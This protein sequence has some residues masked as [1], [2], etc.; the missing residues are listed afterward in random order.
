VADFVV[1]VFVQLDLAESVD[2]DVHRCGLHTLEYFFRQQ[3]FDYVCVILDRRHL[4]FEFSQRLRL[5]FFSLLSFKLFLPQLFG[6]SQVI[7]V[8]FFF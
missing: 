4:L 7:L 1:V 3:I 5:L 8:A 6:Q 2:A